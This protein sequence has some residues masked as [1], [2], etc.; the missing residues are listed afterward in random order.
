MEAGDTA[1]EPPPLPGAGGGTETS[2]PGTSPAGGPVDSWDADT[3]EPLL[4]PDQDDEDLD[5]EAEDV[6][7][8]LKVIKKK[9]PKAE[10]TKSKKEHINVVFI[11]HVGK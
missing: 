6:E 9:P 3:D 7:A 5:A 1:E 10:E 11:G 8:P 2:A 4:T